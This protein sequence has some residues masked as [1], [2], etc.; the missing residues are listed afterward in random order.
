MFVSDVD[1]RGEDSQ[2]ADSLARIIQETDPAIAGVG[3]AERPYLSPR[4]AVSSLSG[5]ILHRPGQPKVMV[6]TCSNEHP[7]QVHY[8]HNPQHLLS[9]RSHNTGQHDLRFGVTC[10]HFA[11]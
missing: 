6:P 5:A 11:L 10:Q 3:A 9:P 2:L 8:H 1:A 4:C 7:S